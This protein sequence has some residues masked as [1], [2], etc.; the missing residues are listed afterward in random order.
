MATFYDV[1]FIAEPRSWRLLCI[2]NKHFAIQLR[3][4]VVLFISTILSLNNGLGDTPFLGW[5]SWNKFGCNIDENIVRRQADK[6]IE[7]GLDKL[8][9]VYVN[10]DDCWMTT[11]RRNGYFVVDNERFPSGMKAL[12]DYIH[13]KGLKFGIYSSAGTYTC[14]KRAGSL[15]NEFKDAQSFASYGVDLLKYDNCFNEG[16]N[17]RIDT[18]NR[19]S[20]MGNALSQQNRTILYSICQWGEE[21]PW[22]WASKIANTFRSTADIG[23][24]FDGEDPLCPCTTTNCTE[25]GYNCSVLNILDK[26]VPITQYS[27]PGFFNDMDMLEVGNGG[28][29]FEEQK[30]HFFL[31][32]ALKSPLVIG[33]DLRTISEQD[34]AILQLE[35]VIKVNQDPL[36]VSAKLLKRVAQKYDIWEGPLVD[37]SVLV[38]FNRSDDPLQIELPVTMI[39]SLN[40]KGMKIV[41][42]DLLT[43]RTV[44]FVVAYESPRIKSHDSVMLKLECGKIERSRFNK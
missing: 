28:M 9:Y 1:M 10:V 2:F 43:L 29:T 30:S 32:A 19:Y 12:G 26:Q 5:N 3:M 6:I 16:L 40:C 27:Q 13:S 11:E 35:E 44:E 36:G 23:D 20:T 7:Y 18:I 42:T 25:F 8:G 14:Q 24:R 39:K 21:Q 41:A 31:W 17:N 22:E 33:A 4:S 37:G 38:L 34:L 15:G